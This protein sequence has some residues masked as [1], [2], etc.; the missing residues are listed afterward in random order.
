MFE[1]NNIS[2]PGGWAS[3]KGSRVSAGEVQHLVTR[4]VNFRGIKSIT[5]QGSDTMRLKQE[6]KDGLNYQIEI[7]TTLRNLISSRP[8]PA[9][10]H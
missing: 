4:V 8:G 10:N 9:G 6:T 2:S 3:A 1:M 7:G 5:F